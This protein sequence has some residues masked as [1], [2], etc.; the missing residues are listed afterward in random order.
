MSCRRRPIMR[1]STSLGPPGVKATMMVT[2]WL[3]YSAA[4][5]AA[6]DIVSATARPARAVVSRLSIS[7]PSTAFPQPEPPL[8]PGG[9]SAIDG[10]G[11]AVDEARAL[12]CQKYHDIGDFLRGAHPADRDFCN[13]RL[14][15]LGLGLAGLRHGVVDVLVVPVGPHRGR[16][17]GVDQDAVL[18]EFVGQRHGQV[19]HRG[20]VDAGGDGT[21]LRRPGCA[22]RDV[23]DAPPFA[24][25]HRRYRMA[26]AA[27]RAA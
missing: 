10:P 16:H 6:S 26:D 9:Y 23:D 22:A 17:D 20:I 25:A 3:G 18:A 15:H 7:L 14:Q 24:L 5:G 4:A 13:A 8:K 12:G 2:G 27:H 1:D 19:L 11:A 21:E